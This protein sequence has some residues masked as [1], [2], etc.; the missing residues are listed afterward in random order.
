M[1]KHHRPSRKVDDAVRTQRSNRALGTWIGSRGIF[2]FRL[3]SGLATG[4]D[5]R[6]FYVTH[7]IVSPTRG[8]A[9]LTSFIPVAEFIDDV[10]HVVLAKAGDTGFIYQLNLHV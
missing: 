6:Y 2:P 4:R 5:E 10:N 8:H 1:F 3:T 9:A 7:F